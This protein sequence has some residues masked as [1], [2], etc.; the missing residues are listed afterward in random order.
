MTSDASGMSL[1]YFVAKCHEHHS[2]I[3]IYH[4]YATHLM[5]ATCQ[6]QDAPKTRIIPLLLCVGILDS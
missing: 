2:E 3:L 4:D 6:T 1:Y 5:L